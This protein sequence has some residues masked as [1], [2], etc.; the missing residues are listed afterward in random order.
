MKIKAVLFDL[1]GTLLNTLD[2]IADAANH[3]LGVMGYPTHEV[4]AYRYFVGMGA[5][6]L[7]SAIAPPG[8]PPEELA[9]LKD[10]YSRRYGAHSLDKTRP[11]AGVPEM[12]RALAEIPVKL[13]VVSNKPDEDANLT[14]SRVYGGGLFDVVAG[15]RRGIPLKPDPTIVGIILE[16]FG[17]VPAESIFVGDTGVDLATAGNAGCVSVGVTWGFRP[18]EVRAFGADYVIDDPSEL[19]KIALSHG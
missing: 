9:S 18:D 11:Y 17:V 1:D 10:I 3:S 16:R 7:I 5:D 19:P 14:V 6:N 8:R 15:G 2:D 4:G 13:A 12:V